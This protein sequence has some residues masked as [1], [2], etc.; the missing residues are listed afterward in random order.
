MICIPSQKLS[1]EVIERN[2]LEYM[3]IRKILIE[4]CNYD[5]HEILLVYFCNNRLETK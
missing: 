1:D 5:I 2:V 4:G 3:M